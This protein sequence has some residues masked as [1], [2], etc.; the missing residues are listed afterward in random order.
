M[1]TTTT[2]VYEFSDPSAFLR[3]CLGE[4][5]EQNP[6]FS[7]RAWARQLGFSNPA[8]LSRVLRGDR[9]LTPRLASQLAEKL[10]LDGDRRRYFELLA[11]Y[12]RAHAPAEKTLYGDVLETIKPGNST[13]QLSLDCFRAISEWY[14]L[15]ILEMLNLK[16]FRADSH[17]ISKRL[18]GAV[19]PEHVDLAIQ[20]LIRLNLIRRT[21]SGKLVRI[22]DA[23]LYVGQELPNDGIRNF[24]L[25]MIKKAQE[26]LEKHPVQERDLSSTVVTLRKGQLAK[27]KSLIKRFHSEIVSQA[28]RRDGEETYVFNTQLFKVTEDTHK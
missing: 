28:A 24:H 12:T 4:K 26:A 15:V 14:H 18:G 21:A 22:P 3:A 10:K 16:G 6:S 7:L 23:K 2:D 11:L 27:C 20:R 5:K 19:S 13:V 1:S 17:W 8:I 25:Q 9:L